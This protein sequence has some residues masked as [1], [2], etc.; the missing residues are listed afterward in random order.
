MIDIMRIPDDV[1]IFCEESDNSDV[2][3]DFEIKNRKLSVYITAQKNRPRFICLRWNFAVHNETRIMGD[4]WERS[5]GDMEWHSLNGEI[6]MPWYFLAH[7][8]TE[9]VG[10]GVMTGANSF[11]SFQCDSS[12]CTAW[13][14]VRNGGTGVNLNGRTLLAG[15]IVCE[16]YKEMSAFKA[17]SK[18]CRVMCEKP[19]LP[20]EPVYG[21]NNWYYAYGKSSRKDILKDAEIIAELAG[22]N[23]N[24]PYMVIDDGWSLKNGVGP[25]QPNEKFGDMSEIALEIKKKGVKPGIWFR[26]L[27]DEKIEKEHPEWRLKKNENVCNDMVWDKT[28]DGYL[29]FLDPTVPEVREY[30][31]KTI[32]RFKEWGFDLIKQDFSTYDMF[33]RYG[34]Y[35]NGKIT[36]EDGWSFSDTTKT[37]AEIVL[38]FYRLIREEAGDMIVIGCNT[39]SHL[40]AGLVELYRIGD[41]TSGM[42]WSRTRAYGVNTLAFRLCQNDAFYKVDAD[43][44]GIIKDK[45]DWKLNRQWLDL[46]AR[47][48]SPLFVS[49]QPQALTD[50]IKCDLKAAFKANSVQDD[51]AEPI[52][53]LYNNQPCLW[54]ISNNKTEYDF[55]MDS[56]PLLL[57]QK[58]QPC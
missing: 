12:G 14:D 29:T 34:D 9:T 30:L 43:C 17:A 6:F 45:I 15:I 5:Y 49:A 52:D 55:I 57:G 24:K 20:K 28:D 11:V 22:E 41:D 33:G 18:F 36:A 44:V 35:L 58:I 10:C 48:G 31:R 19:R 37:S 2:S 42:I 50:E 13:F 1:R 26:P 23:D 16:H 47:S 51:V 3:V 53:W 4:K 25:W 8:G 21:S 39:I 56:Y 27:H 40:S 32:R 54:M 38:D 46:L 7:S